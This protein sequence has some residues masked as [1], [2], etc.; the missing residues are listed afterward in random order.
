MNVEKIQL[1]K[2]RKSKCWREAGQICSIFH[3]N[4]EATMKQEG[5]QVG[6]IGE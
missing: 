1:S 3:D 2:T 6:K 4:Y 5:G